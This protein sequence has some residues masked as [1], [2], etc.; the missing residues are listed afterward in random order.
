ML[1]RE[2]PATRQDREAEVS[3]PL[4]TVFMD[5]DSA[6]PRVSVPLVLGRTGENFHHLH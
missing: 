1:G 6:A 4:G 5:Q 3:L 2:S